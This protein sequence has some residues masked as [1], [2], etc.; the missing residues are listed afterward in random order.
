MLTTFDGSNRWALCNSSVQ[1]TADCAG[2]AVLYVFK[3]SRSK[4]SSFTPSHSIWIDLPTACA[5]PFGP[6]M[7]YFGPVSPRDAR[8]TPFIEANATW[9][10]FKPFHCEIGVVR[11]TNREM[12]SP[13]IS[14]DAADRASSSW[15]A[16]DVP[17][18]IENAS[19]V[20]RSKPSAMNGALLVSSDSTW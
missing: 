10:E 13:Q 20:V 16:F 14:T 2:I 1:K 12:T 4:Q 19:C 11:T 6:S 3:A 15:S 9:D 8:K 7:T 18:A 5:S 17:A